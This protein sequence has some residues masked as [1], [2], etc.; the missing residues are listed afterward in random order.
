MLCFSQALM[1][2]KRQDLLEKGTNGHNAFRTGG[3]IHFS[4]KNIL[5]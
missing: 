4:E 2:T 3:K 5:G 1:H